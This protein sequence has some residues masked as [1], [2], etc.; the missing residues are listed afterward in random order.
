MLK[1]TIKIE[2]Y[3]YF[4][5]FIGTIFLANW[6]VHNVGTEC[7]P[8]G[9]CVIPVWF[10]PLIFAP[11]GVLAIGLGFTLRDLVQRR[12]GVLFTFVGIVVG[13]LISMLIDPFLGLAS[14]TAFLFS[15]TMDL[16]VYTPLQK[17]NMF[18]AVI[19]SNIV[20]LIADSII[21]LYLAF[22]SIQFIEGQIIGKLW[23]TLFAFPIV[24]GIREWDRKRGI[25]EI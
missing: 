24:W 19:G 6:L 12:L 15:E 2:G 17:R 1:R 10:N 3:I 8:D 7:I 4:I 9:P 21:F 16:A 22:G 18:L 11:S 14:G 23:M 5:L 20:G 13:A 25:S